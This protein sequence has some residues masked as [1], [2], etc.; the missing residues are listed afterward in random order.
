MISIDH[1]IQKFLFIF[2]LL[3]EAESDKISNGKDAEEGIPDILIA[4]AAKL[5][6]LLHNNIY[7]L[8]LPEN[9]KSALKRLKSFI[10]KDKKDCTTKNDS[11]NSSR[12]EMPISKGSSSS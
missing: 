8:K 1:E 10:V 3:I 11:R 7:S 12:P 6:Q 2:N 4:I 9:I 5:F